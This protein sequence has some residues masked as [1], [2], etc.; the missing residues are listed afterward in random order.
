M[1]DYSGRIARVAG[2]T[3]QA[4][5]LS[6]CFMNEIARVGP[7]GL[8]GEI[9]RIE[10]DLATIQVYEETV[11]L[12]VG[13]PVRTT[14]ELLSVEL[15]PGLVGEIFDG[16]QRPLPRLSALSGDFIQKG[17]EAK[18]L[19]RE[20]LWSFEARVKKGDLVEWGT[21]LGAVKETPR[22]SHLVFAAKGVR[23]LVDEVREGDFAVTEPVVILEGGETITM[24]QKW[25]VRE[26]RPVRGRLPLETPLLTGQ[27][28]V[29]T[30]FPIAE[31][32]TAVIPGGFGS[33]KTVIEQTIAKYASADL[34]VYIGCGERGNE[35]ADTL[36]QF[37]RLTDPYAGRP[38]MERTILIA[39]TSNMPVAAREASI[40]TGVTI[41]EYYR[42]MG[43]RVA[44]L[45]D[46]TSRWAEALRE[47]SSRLEEIPGEEGY[48]TYLASR[49]S[50]FYER[51]GR[52]LLIGP[53]EKRTGSVTI[54][55][56]VSPPGGDFSEPVTQASLQMASTFWALDT[57]LANQRHFPAINWRM[58]FSLTYPSLLKWY[59][60]LASSEWSSLVRE[61][62]EVLQQ[63]EDLA[64]IVR[65]IGLDSVADRERVLLEAARM[66]REGYLRQSAVHPVDAYCSIRRQVKL[67]STFVFCT[68]RMF[69]AAERGLP[70]DLILGAPPLEALLRLKEVCDEDLDVRIAELRRDFSTS[71]GAGVV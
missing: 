10:G 18:R 44:V 8:T 9:I 32:G 52:F 55:G 4:R 70:L 37:P 61:V 11:G 43:Y 3:V 2:P 62:H 50:A 26:P 34:I 27:R 20:R 19:D 15:G 25:N 53:D 64:E 56:A 30:L 36:S 14:G 6:G 16:I 48:P 51:A 40:F 39:N 21:I 42:D 66:L 54:I 71:L 47:I 46:S 7:W 59:R 13:D 29:D 63:E 23:G 35:M 57:D 17:A 1:N 33:G 65:I 60:Q 12:K 5:G 22:I 31:G 45:A 28:T 24:R 41:A 67:L 69:A 38:L 58:S 49:L 68:G